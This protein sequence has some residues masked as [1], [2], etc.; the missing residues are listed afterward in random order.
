MQIFLLL[1]LRLGLLLAGIAL[2]VGLLVSWFALRAGVLLCRFFQLFLF[3]RLVTRRGPALYGE[4]LFPVI[5]R[6][7]LF[8]PFVK[9]L[10]GLTRSQGHHVGGVR[11]DLGAGE[12]VARAVED[13]V[14]GVIVL[15]RNRVELVVVAARATDAE[16]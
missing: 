7:E 12:G 5:Q 4:V 14:E 6:G 16:T 2:I 8:L 9:L 1:G 15:G 3:G 13:T 10:S 11:V